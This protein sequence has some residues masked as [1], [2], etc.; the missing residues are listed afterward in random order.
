MLYIKTYLAPS[1]IHGIGLFAAEEIPAETL[2][3]K[4][5]P[6][7]DLAFTPDD[8]KNLPPPSLE[9]IRRYSYFDMHLKLHVL[10]GD[11]ARFMNHSDDANTYETRDLS[12]AKREIAKDEEI[13][14]D[15]RQFDLEIW[16]KLKRAA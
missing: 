14:S 15:Y 1:S 12:I 8:L 13:T 3:W 4:M 16:K 9:A 11:D 2:I 7:F 6:P 10:C 5:I